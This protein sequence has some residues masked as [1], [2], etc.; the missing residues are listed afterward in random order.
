V[1]GSTGARLPLCAAHLNWGGEPVCATVSDKDGPA[2][3]LILLERGL[4]VPTS[5]GERCVIVLRAG[6]GRGSISVWRCGDGRVT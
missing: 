3:S 6:R 4:W 5:P 1:G 2:G